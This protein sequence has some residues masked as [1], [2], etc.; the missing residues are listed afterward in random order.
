M[1]VVIRML[2]HHLWLVGEIV[3]RTAAVPD[4]VL[5]R[6]SSCPSRASTGRPRCAASP[7]GSSASWR[8]GWTR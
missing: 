4:E 1:D 5:D 3:D 6:P 7:T 2:D 8:C